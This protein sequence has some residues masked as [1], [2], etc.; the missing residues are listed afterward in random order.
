[1]AVALI[2]LRWEALAY[3]FGAVAASLAALDESIN[4]AY[5]NDDIRLCIMQRA[6]PQ[7]KIGVS[8]LYFAP[9]QFHYVKLTADLPS[10]L[11][12]RAGLKNYDRIIFLNGLNIE[13][14][15]HNK[16]YSRFD[17]T[18]HLPIQML[19]C[20]PATYTYYKTNKKQF[21]INL[22]TIQHLTPVFATSTSESH[23]E[24][25][26]VS[27]DNDSFYAVRWENSDIVST[28]S[29]SAVFKSPEFTHVNDICY[30]ETKGQYRKGQIIA[31]G[32]FLWINII[33]KEFH[34]FSGSRS[35]YNK[36]DPLLMN[37]YAPFVTRL[38]IPTNIYCDFK[39][40]PNLHELVLCIENSKQFSQIQPDVIPNLTHLSFMLGSKFT[41][42]M[43]LIWN[44]F[45]NG[46]SSLRQVNLSHIDVS[47]CRSWPT[48][49]SL[50]FVSIL[51]CKPMDIPVILASC[52]CLQHLQVHISLNDNDDIIIS[53]L[54][55]NHPLRRL[56][57]WSDYT[58]LTSDVIDS[59]L[60]Y[61]PNIE[62]FYLQTIYSMSL[63]DLA[64]GLA[65]RLNYLSQ[66]DCYITEM[67]ARNCRINNLTDLHQI[68]PCFYRIQVIEENDDFRIL[69]TK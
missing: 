15:T 10:S 17:T 69:A 11:A 23:T 50:Q 63:I 52:P 56:T 33:Q 35:D 8:L 39:Q 61:T 9:K 66:F 55:L 12:R 28:V 48:S 25:P 41:L 51:S 60:T 5:T 30:I 19:V 4:L 44:V 16:F 57:L 18:R 26:A 29:Q 62:C 45:S 7:Q 22:P 13:N 21:H 37:L 54:L 67:L 3:A 24:I 36:V 47:L 58:E 14:D 42:P 53:S 64:H 20:S 32:L 43:E 59:I 34:S 2:P 31:K 1:M 27:V 49:P 38:I 40:F 6:I 68:H 65:N 46:F